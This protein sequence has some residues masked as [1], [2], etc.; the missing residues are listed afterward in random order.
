MAGPFLNLTLLVGL[1]PMLFGVVALGP[2][3]TVRRLVIEDQLIIRVP[4]QTRR[5]PAIEWRESKGPKCVDPSFIAG[6]ML[7]GRSS[8]DFLLRDRHRIR[9]ELDDDC[10]ALDFYGGFYLQPEDENL[11]ARRDVIRSR[12]GGECRI[13]R[14]RTLEPKLRD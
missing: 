1:W 14:F 7:S 3:D 2:G 13:E 11:C 9:A 6:A 8:V 4:V 10:P 5:M 12:M